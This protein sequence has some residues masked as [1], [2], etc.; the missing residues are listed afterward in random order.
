MYKSEFFTR[1]R[2]AETDQMGFVYYGNYATFLEIGRVE[3][4][5]NL[6]ISYK[7]L[8][9]EGYLMPVTDL[10]IKYIS[11]AF[12]DDEIAIHTYINEWP[13]A[14]IRFDY[15]IYRGDTK[16]IVA[17]TYLVFIN[18]ETKKIVRMPKVLLEALSPYFQ[19]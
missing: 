11:P 17:H 13:G 18:V 16:L 10:N 15:E 5:R 19:K 9:I 7:S 1:I 14:R 6:G 4:F 8:E 2:Y 3:A 12:Y